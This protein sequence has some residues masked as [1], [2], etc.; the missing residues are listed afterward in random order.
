VSSS[1]YPPN[2]G[3]GMVRS[4]RSTGEDP[5]FWYYANRLNARIL[6]NA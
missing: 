2:R 6:G 3:T 4:T 5:S 1:E